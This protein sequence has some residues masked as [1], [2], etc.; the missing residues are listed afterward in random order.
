MTK[1]LAL[2]KMKAALSAA[3]FASSITF[4]PSLAAQTEPAA[5]PPTNSNIVRSVRG[6]YEYRDLSTGGPRGSETFTLL[7]HPDGT[8][9]MNAITD[10]YSRDVNVVST[11][12]VDERFRP[13]DAFVTIRTAGRLKGRGSFRL[14]RNILHSA[15]DGPAGYIETSE[16]LPDAVSF[17]THPI[18][19]DGWHFWAVQGDDTITSTKTLYIDGSANFSE[20]MLGRLIDAEIVSLGTRQVT[21][22]AGT[23][24]ARGFLL[25]KNSEIW[26]ATEDDL[27]VEYTWKDLDRLYVLTSLEITE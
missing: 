23:F 24:E 4:A 10:I 18:S 16:K 13:L 14:D 26:I 9:T 17:L 25:A 8:R 11:L 19:M 7:V 5:S 22:P 15:V 2:I 20:P 21:V 3:V 27:V 1:R 6:S 12:S